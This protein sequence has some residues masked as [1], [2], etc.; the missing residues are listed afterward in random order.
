MSTA[1]TEAPE[2]FQAGPRADFLCSRCEE[3]GRMTEPVTLPIRAAHCPMCGAKRWLQRIWSGAGS[4]PTI[5]Q[6]DRHAKSQFT[7]SLGIDKQWDAQQA[8]KRA[9][10]EARS[11]GVGAEMM[12]PEAA[13]RRLEAVNQA[14]REQ[15]RVQSVSTGSLAGLGLGLRPGTATAVPRLAHQ[16]LQAIGGPRP[17][18]ESRNGGGRIVREGGRLKGQL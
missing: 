10:V 2:R 11:K 16:A 15:T 18:P 8:Q 9:A 12:S 3:S 4:M 13:A 14:V 5:I 7:K 6:A 1:P 17:G